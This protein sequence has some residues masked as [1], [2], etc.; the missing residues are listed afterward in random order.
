MLHNNN[1]AA[2]GDVVRAF[3]EH[4]NYMAVDNTN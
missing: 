4:F 2:A 3:A 1:N